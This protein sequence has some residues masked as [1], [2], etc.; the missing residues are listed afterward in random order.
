MVMNRKKK[1]IAHSEGLGKGILVVGGGIS[2]ITTALEA[3]EVGYRV[4]LIEQQAFLGGKVSM[5]NQYFPKLCPPWC[6]LEI[7]FRR[8]RQNPRIQVFTSTTVK[9]ISGSEGNFDVKLEMKPEYVNDQCTT[10]GDC[11]E[12]CPVE[13][14]NDFN[15][16]LDKTRAIFLP[17]EMAFPHKYV[18]DEN[19]CLKEECRKCQEVCK[20]DAI[21]FEQFPEIIELKIGSIVFATGWELFDVSQIP[22]LKFG[23]FPDIITNLMM[24]RMASLDGPNKGKIVKPSNGEAPKNIVF[25]QCAG[26]RDES[27]LPYCSGVCC[28]VSLKQALYVTEQYPEANVKIF[29]IDLRLMG[30]HE[31]FLNRIL[32]NPRIE[33]IKGKVGKISEE[34]ETGNMICEAEDVLSGVKISSLADLVVLAAGMVPN[35]SPLEQIATDESGFVSAEKLEPGIYA[36]GCNKNPQEVS[37]SLKDA[38]GTALKAI[39][40]AKQ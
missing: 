16:G 21:N 17:H 15:L 27:Y 23:V 5:M 34:K 13:K 24:E 3:A 18:I 39:Q 38:T 40:S 1:V 29:Y 7:N 25:V 22:E 33:L 31:D 35:V 19:V 30:R 14:D 9:K 10:C 4:V 12:V 37:L 36:A 20:Y 2:G 26:S 8:I 28:S 11:V 32:D 6:G